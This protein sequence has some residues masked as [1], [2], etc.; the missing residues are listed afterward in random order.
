MSPRRT[1]WIDEARVSPV[2][3]RK[4]IPNRSRRGERWCREQANLTETNDTEDHDEDGNDRVALAHDIDSIG[5]EE[6]ADEGCDADPDV[7]EWMMQ[8]RDAGE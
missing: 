2:R 3:P 5:V 6:L 1:L 4:D 7:G 8:E